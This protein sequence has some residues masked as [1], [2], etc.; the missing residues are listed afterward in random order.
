VYASHRDCVSVIHIHSGRIAPL[1]YC[2]EG[3]I[4]LV[5]HATA[6]WRAHRPDGDSNERAWQVIRERRGWAL[7]YLRDGREW[8]FNNLTEALEAVCRTVGPGEAA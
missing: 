2:G 3:D 5:R 7:V 8:E 4:G 6:R 1:V